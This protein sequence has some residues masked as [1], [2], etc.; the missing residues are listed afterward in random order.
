ME[1]PHKTSFCRFLTERI[2]NNSRTLSRVGKKIS[3]VAPF[4]ISVVHPP[5]RYRSFIL[6]GAAVAKNISRIHKHIV[7]NCS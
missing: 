3:E 4:M 7:M 1:T 6:Y 2:P 5:S